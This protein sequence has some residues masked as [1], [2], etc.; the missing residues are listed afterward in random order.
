M[1]GLVRIRKGDGVD[2]VAG[3]VEHAHGHRTLVSDRRV[4]PQLP[5]HLL[6]LMTRS[7]GAVEFHAVVVL[8]SLGARFT[9]DGEGPEFASPGAAEHEA[10]CAAAE[11]GRDRLPTGRRA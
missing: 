5:G 2:E 10:A 4:L 7:L 1:L 6:R 9:P 11:I 8:V 3:A